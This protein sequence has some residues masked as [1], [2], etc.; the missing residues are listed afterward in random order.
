MDDQQRAWSEAAMESG[1]ETLD[2]Y[3]ALCRALLSPDASASL[4]HWLNETSTTG[5]ADIYEL[6]ERLVGYDPIWA[7]ER[8]AGLP[9]GSLAVVDV[10]EPGGSD[11]LAH[12]IVEGWW[13]DEGFTAAEVTTSSLAIEGGRVRALC[14]YEWTPTEFG[15]G[16]PVCE[17][18][19]EIAASRGWSPPPSGA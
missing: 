10:P 7:L 13:T 14:G 2:E 16:R 4:S 1:S 3:R 11:K 17:E 9:E 8:D 12:I 6:Y 5:E 19:R 15:S 18:C